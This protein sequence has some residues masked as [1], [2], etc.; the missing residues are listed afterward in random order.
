MFNLVFILFYLVIFVSIAQFSSLSLHQ[1]LVYN[2]NKAL[3]NMTTNSASFIVVVVFLIRNVA[4][5]FFFIIYIYI[6]KGREKKGKGIMKKKCFLVFLLYFSLYNFDE[7]S[8]RMGFSLT[9][10]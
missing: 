1:T 8:G 4:W 5:S 3:P 9:R 10:I 2:L 6:L 7:R